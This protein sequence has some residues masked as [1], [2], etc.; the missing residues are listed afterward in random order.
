MASTA[1]EGLLSWLMLLPETPSDISFATLRA[2][3]WP[4]LSEALTEASLQLKN[5]QKVALDIA[6]WAPDIVQIERSRVDIY[7]HAQHLTAVIYHLICIICA[8]K[9]IDTDTGNNVDTRVILVGQGQDRMRVDGLRIMEGPLIDLEHLSRSGRAWSCV[10]STGRGQ[11]ILE[12]FVTNRKSVSGVSSFS[13]KG[14]ADGSTMTCIAPLTFGEKSTTFHYSV[15]VGGTF[16]HLHA[17]HKLLLTATALLLQPV[18]NHNQIVHRCL[19]IGITG[20][21]LLKNKKYASCMQSWQERQEA[22][23]QFL[24]AI[25]DLDRHQDAGSA[26]QRATD[27]E[28]RVTVTYKLSSAL[29]IRCVEIQD[30]FGPTITDKA[31]TALVISGET[32]SGGKAVNDRRKG[33]G[34]PALSVYE[35]EVLDQ[36]SDER[37]S[38]EL[39]SDFQGKISSTDIRRRLHEKRLC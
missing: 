2:A 35:V 29:E 31:I 5:R 24:R 39:N 30:P 12:S 7:P 23:Y 11:S 32:R 3:Y 28:N 20:D 38:D 1:T 27:G 6:V 14:L 18:T 10:F 9:D 4:A 33:M 13:V 36:S 17:G 15:A 8:E 16:D 25:I 19:T 21:E 26:G 22:V 37:L 34:W